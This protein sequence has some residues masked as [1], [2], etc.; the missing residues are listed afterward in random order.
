MM[1]A[2][3]TQGLKPDF[4]IIQSGAFR[5]T[6]YPGDISYRELYDMF[7]FNSTIVKFEIKGSDLIEMLRRV[8]SGKK[9]FYFCD[10][11]FQ[12]VSLTNKTINGTN[13]KEKGFINATLIDGTPINLDKTYTGIISKFL[14]GGGDDFGRAF[15][16]YT[17]TDSGRVYPPLPYSNNILLTG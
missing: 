5:S 2:A 8:Q 16:G 15:K 9:G 11:L 6:W 12:T 17:D 3:K 13:I 7:P 10:G 14:F 4:S 1:N